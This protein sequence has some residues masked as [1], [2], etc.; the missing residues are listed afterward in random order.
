MTEG[1]PSA[2]LCGEIKRLIVESL[3]LR[4]KTENDIGDDEA[5]FGGRLGLDSLDALELAVAIERRF[6][7]EVP[8]GDEGR[9]A[10]AS[11]AALARYVE[12]KRQGAP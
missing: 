6:G 2:E 4:S 3:D 12:A 8:E 1:A 5:L 9:R 10:F 7:V 11:V